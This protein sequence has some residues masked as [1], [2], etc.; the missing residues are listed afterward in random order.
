M[1]DQINA[2]LVTSFKNIGKSLL[3]QSLLY[4]NFIE[5]V[6]LVIRVEE[7]SDANQLFEP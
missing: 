2:T 6:F 3:F 4:L 5:E 1:F 7:V